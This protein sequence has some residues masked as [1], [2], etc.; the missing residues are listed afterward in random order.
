MLYSKSQRLAL[1]RYPKT[2]GTSLT[3]W[4]ESTFP[5][6]VWAQP[7]DPHIPVF[8][9]LRRLR[10][11]D[12]QPRSAWQRIL[13]NMSVWR[14]PSPLR[15]R[16]LIIGVLREPLEMLVSLY[17]Y[18]RRLEAS[19]SRPPGSPAHT[20]ATQGFR[21]F[22]MVSVVQ[23]RL[24]NYVEFFN[25]GGPAWPDTRLLDFRH[26]ES[27]LRAVCRDHGIEP[28]ASLPVANIAPHNHDFEAF[29]DEVTDLL[30]AIRLRFR[31]YY[32]EAQS[33]MVRDDAEALGHKAA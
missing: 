11:I 32:E 31:W 21:E 7:G 15:R 19:Y 24:P 9:S 18:W 22:V 2:A 14:S 5:D 29:F 17:A 12:D 13:R 23:K 25:V 27:G 8:E 1:A 33:I 3:A 10:L 6:G 4:F 16:I 28:P 26:L 30:P 20:A